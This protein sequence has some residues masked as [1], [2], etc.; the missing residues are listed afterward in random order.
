MKFLL[1]AAGSGGHI[2]PAIATAD[3]L[4]ALIPDCHIMFV[5]AGRPMEKKLVPQAGYELTN[6]EMQGISRGLNPKKL[7]YNVNSAKMLLTANRRAAEL[8]NEYKPDAVIGTGGYICYPVLRTAV[9]AGIPTAIHES[10]AQPG[11]TIKMLSGMVSRVFTAY[12]GTEQFYRDPRRVKCIGTP[13][14]QG[15]SDYTRARARLELGIAEDENVVVSMWGSLGASGMN[16][17]M[18]A[19]IT[20]NMREHAFR[21]IHAVGTEKGA[22]TLRAAVAGDLPLPGNIE[23][24]PYIDDMARVMAAA[25]LI[26]S[27]SGGSTLAELSA[28]GRAAVLVPS[29]YV[30]NDEQAHNAQAVEAAG[31]AVVATEADST[32]DSLFEMVSALL[33]TPRIIEKMEEAQKSLGA[34]DAASK[35]AEEIIALLS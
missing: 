29:P 26:M 31:G 20:R 21:H 4:R 12:G 30:S 25:N 28:L 23:I 9:K 6:I 11:L 35:F 14:R 34:A 24:R 33:K 3:A 10:N 8:I 22:E 2:N 16:E 15:F 32:G 13:V 27:R 17:K 19:F 7:A 1:A 18:K 5:G